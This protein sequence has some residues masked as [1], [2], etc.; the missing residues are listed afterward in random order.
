VKITKKKGGGGTWKIQIN[1]LSKSFP[2]IGMKGEIVVAVAY[3]RSHR[4]DV[5][6][7]RIEV[8]PRSEAKLARVAAAAAACHGVTFGVLLSSSRHLTMTSAFY[9]NQTSRPNRLWDVNWRRRMSHR[10]STVNVKWSNSSK[11]E[12]KIFIF[13]LVNFDY[14]LVETDYSLVI[15]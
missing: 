6:L 2:K 10:K 4:C 5:E 13:Q 9:S 15:F 12:A 7:R 14:F 11:E 1:S 8:F 3:Q